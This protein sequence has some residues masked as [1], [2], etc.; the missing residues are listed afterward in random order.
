[1]KKVIIII[2]IFITSFLFTFRINA[3]E[4]NGLKKLKPSVGE[5]VPSFN[6]NIFNYN[7]FLD[8]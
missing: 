7:I 8:E 6:K 2:F 3:S 5:L 4:E 1:M